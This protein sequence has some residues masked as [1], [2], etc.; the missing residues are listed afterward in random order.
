MTLTLGASGSAVEV[1]TG[2][3]GIPAK[4]GGKRERVEAVIDA[5]ENQTAVRMRTNFSWE[6]ADNTC[7]ELA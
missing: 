5:F 4:S 3:K 7:H 2:V 1:Q 6:G